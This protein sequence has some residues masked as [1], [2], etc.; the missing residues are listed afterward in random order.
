MMVC[1]LTLQMRLGLAG[2]KN[3]FGSERHGT[4]QPYRVA[5]YAVRSRCV[6]LRQNR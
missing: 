6:S 1:W 4:Y 2:R 3:R 5:R